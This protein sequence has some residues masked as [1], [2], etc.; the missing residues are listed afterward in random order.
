MRA[1]SRRAG[2]ISSSCPWW[3]SIREAVVW[4][5][6]ADS[7]IARSPFGVTGS[8]WKGPRLVGLGF[9]CQRTACVFADPWDVRLDALA[10]ESGCETFPQRTHSMN[11][12]LMKSEPDT[13]SIDHLAALPET[14]DRLGRRAQ[15][16][17][18]QHAA[19]L[20]ENRRYGLFLSLRLRGPGHRRH[21]P[22]GEGGLCG[23]D[24]L[25]PE[26]SSLRRR[27]QSHAILAGS[28]ST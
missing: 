6:A 25:R 3:E 15:L 16:P 8:H 28:W 26:A 9:D 7:T 14:D 22:R 1:A 20:H 12:W 11:H 4:G 2:S 10:T 24:R 27:Q 18:A 13:F 19:R 23:Q 21:R 5:W 17:G